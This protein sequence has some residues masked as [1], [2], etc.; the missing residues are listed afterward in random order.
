MKNKCLKDKD[1]ASVELWLAPCRCA[2]QLFTHLPPSWEKLE[3]VEVGQT[4]ISKWTFLDPVT[5]D[6]L[7][8]KVTQCVPPVFSVC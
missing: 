8:F 1:G 2:G 7:L 6:L 4:A 3:K 5:F